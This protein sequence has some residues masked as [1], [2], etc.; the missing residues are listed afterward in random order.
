M[1]SEDLS[2]VIICSCASAEHQMIFR[3]FND[4]SDVYVN[5]H[6]YT[7]DNFFKRLWHGLKYA[8]GYKSRFGAWDEIIIGKEQLPQMK[9]VIE[10]IELNSLENN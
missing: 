1:K 4:D 2:E 3:G 9:K 5:V 10:H 8:F 7:H 6:L